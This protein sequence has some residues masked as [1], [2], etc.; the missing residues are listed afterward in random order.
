M[1]KI[2]WWASFSSQ[3]LNT[4]DEITEIDNSG[5]N[6]QNPTVF[7]GNLGL[8]KYIVQVCPMSIRLLEG[9]KEIQDIQMGSD[10]PNVTF[11][12]I[13]DP[14]AVLLMADGSIMYMQLIEDFNGPKLKLIGPDIRLVSTQKMISL[15]TKS[16]WFLFWQDWTNRQNLMFLNVGWSNISLL[17]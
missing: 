5:F 9:S 7:A 12:S 3:V 11:C 2:L 16:I 4:G 1:V 14:H 15:I 10:S 8:D 17:V 6:A 13:A